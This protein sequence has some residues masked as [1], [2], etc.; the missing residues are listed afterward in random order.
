V[1]EHRLA[2][3]DHQHC[4]D[5]READRPHELLGVGLVPLDGGVRHD[6]LDPILLAFT[7]IH[8]KQSAGEQQG[9]KSDNGE[10]CTSRPNST[11]RQGPRESRS[12]NGENKR[13]A[14]RQVHDGWMQW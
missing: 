3:G 7:G 9:L 1:N 8:R 13:Q 11:S 6:A 12:Q 14:K 4:R 2:E 10:P 5:E